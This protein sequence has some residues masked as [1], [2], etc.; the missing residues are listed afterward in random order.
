M[1][2]LIIIA[3]F[4]AG[5]IPFGLLIARAKGVDIRKHGS[6]NI[7]A[8]NV[9]RVLGRRFFFLCFALDLLKGLLPT[10]AMGAALGA[11]GAFTMSMHD[12]AWWLGAAV[13]SILGHVF[14]PWLGFKGGKGV[15]TG[16]GALLGVFP[17]LSVAGGV[18]TIVWILAMLLWRYVSLASIIAAITLAP[19]IG[20]AWWLASRQRTGQTTPEP[21]ML[22][23]VGIGAL[24]TL[25]VVWTHRA[26]IGRLRAG[27]ELRAASKRPA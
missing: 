11:L 14:C 17:L 8:T 21:A 16:L 15:A 10:L 22:L 20:L 13:A 19:T 18:A 2:P 25:L 7:G 3:A 26:N 9:G 23:F 24:L 27:T 5:S 6:G 12:A 4:L 1:L